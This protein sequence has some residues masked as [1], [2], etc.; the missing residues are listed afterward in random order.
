MKKYTPFWVILLTTVIYY[1]PLILWPDFLLA[2]QNDLLQQFIPTWIY[3]KNSLFTYHTLP[4]Y[5]HQIFA[6]TP[7]LPDPQFSLFYPLNWVHIIFPIPFSFFLY[8]F[9]HS[10]IAGTGIYLLLSV[11]KLSYRTRIIGTIIYL[12]S[13][14]FAAILEAGHPNLFAALSFVP[15]TYY[16]TFLIHKNPSPKHISFFALSLAATFFTH[17]VI[18]IYLAISSLIIHLFIG[19]TPT[20]KKVIKN[21]FATFISFLITF[22][23]ISI[24]LFPQLSWVGSS[25]RS[26]LLE[27]PDV[28]PYWHSIKEFMFAL[29][30]PMILAKQLSTETWI[31]IGIGPIILSFLFFLKQ[32]LRQKLIIALILIPSFLI[33]MNNL[34]PLHSF[35]INQNWYKLGR[36]STRLFF[37]PA[38]TVTILSSLA[39]QRFKLVSSF[40][41]PII[42]LELLFVSWFKLTNPITPPKVYAPKQIVDFLAKERSN[43]IFR[44]YCT[45]RCLSPISTAKTHL[46]TID[47]Y[48][49]LIQTNFYQHAWQLTGAYWNHYTLAI[50][51]I[52]TY[53]YEKPLPDPLSLGEYNVKYLLS[54]YPLN[55]SSLKLILEAQSY[56]LYQNLAFQPRSN[57]QI[58]L[59][60]PNKIVLKTEKIE[61]N[62]LS[63]SLVYNPDWKAY[64]SDHKQLSAQ[65]HPN[66]LTQIT[67]IQPTTKVTLIYK[68]KLFL[69]AT[70]LSV[71]TL[72]LCF[73]FVFS[74][75]FPKQKPKAQ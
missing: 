23:L 22:G 34:S 50:P 42:I 62:K 53:Q 56:Y 11:F 25:T 9:I 68:P 46:E 75:K 43:E 45:S 17:T 51:P 24:T 49:T 20:P 1:L 48:N 59:Y 72:L 29:S 8:F 21:Y 19:F 10:L 60:S 15:F 16:F 70:L 18:F 39:I 27:K 55:N 63:V 73:F 54:T 6:G 28:Y 69:P 57:T 31:P 4:L 33:L 26:I 2:R 30:N 58:L 47:G 36:V 71:I 3:V 65:Q 74:Q 64:D 32:P 14:Y 66:A 5:N 52:G 12:Y 41:T 13:P 35:L 7:L 40:I 67:L 61:G 37:I 44:V 38:L